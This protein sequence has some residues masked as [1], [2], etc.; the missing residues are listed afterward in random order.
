MTLSTG[1]NGIGECILFDLF[2][3]EKTN[4]TERYQNMQIVGFSNEK[5]EKLP[6]GSSGA[7]LALLKLF[8][9]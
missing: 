9:H 1:G 3:R 5:H 4:S 2:Q 7:S 8:P 6:Y